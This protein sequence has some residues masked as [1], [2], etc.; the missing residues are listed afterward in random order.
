M[1]RSI[2]YSKDHEIIK[3][4]IHSFKPSRGGW[5]C[6]R[7]KKLYLLTDLSQDRGVQVRVVLKIVYSIIQ[8]QMVCS[9]MTVT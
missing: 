4:D 6:Q 2:S 8:S 5:D 1:L 9:L 3:I 7:A